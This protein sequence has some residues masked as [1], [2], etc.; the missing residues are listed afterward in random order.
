MNSTQKSNVTDRD[1]LLPALDLRLA[2]AAGDKGQSRHVADGLVAQWNGCRS[3]G[4]ALTTPWT[5]RR[6][7]ADGELAGLRLAALRHEHLTAA[8]RSRAFQAFN[9]RGHPARTQTG[10]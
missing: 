7:V 5:A 10:S 2:P 4:F 3:G 1:D 8:G 9:G 6:A